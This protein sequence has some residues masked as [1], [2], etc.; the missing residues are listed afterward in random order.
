MH[1]DERFME[2]ALELASTPAFA[3]PNPRVGAVVVRDGI[4]LGEGAHEGPGTPHAEAVALAGIDA[5]GATAYVTLEPC[6]HQGRTPPC[7][8]ALV[9]AGVTRVVAAVEDPDERVSGTGFDV[10]RRAGVEVDVGVLRERAERV[11]QAYLHHR[12]TGRAFVSLKLAST[13]D[14]RMTAPDGSSQWITGSEARRV[15][16]ARRLECD[17]VMVGAGTVL[18]DDPRLT[19]RD[20]PAPRQPLR[21]L[22]DSAGRVPPGAA[23]LGEGSIVATTAAAPHETQIA[24]KEAGA[25]VL[26]LPESPHGVDLTALVEA[27]GAR[28][29]VEVF[30][31]GGPRLAASLVR[32]D[33]AGRLEL[34]YG[35]LLAGG[36]ASLDDL[37][38]GSMKEALRFEIESTRR[39]G[40]DLLVTLVRRT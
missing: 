16:H 33:L 15:V 34:H 5:R 39:A 35:P 7:A 13:L 10:L 40:D 17:A 36:G 37:G 22:V 4:V 23:A 30:C 27:L 32:Q 12:R 25:E 8:P 1:Q 26:V 19:V 3:S 9:E 28:D 18:A 24:W 2:R 21:V 38:V 20:V 31:E 14:G 29:I 6:N 11:N